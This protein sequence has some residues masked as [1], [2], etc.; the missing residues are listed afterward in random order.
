MLK[1]PIRQPSEISL[2]FH[3][4]SVLRILPLVMALSIYDY[5]NA[6]EFTGEKLKTWRSDILLSF[7]YI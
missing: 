4:Q 1:T 5:I 7:T 3:R 2:Y 6:R